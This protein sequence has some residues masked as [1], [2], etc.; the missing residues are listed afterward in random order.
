MFAKVSKNKA[1]KAPLAVA[2]TLA[3]GALA[4]VIAGSAAVSAQ[5]G[6][7]EAAPSAGAHMAA[8]AMSPRPLTIRSASAKPARTVRVIQL[9]NVPPAQKNFGQR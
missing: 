1:R 3:A 8:L 9:Y 2:L 7:S 4:A 6:G 5:T